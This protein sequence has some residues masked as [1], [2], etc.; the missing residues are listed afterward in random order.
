MELDAEYRPLVSVDEFLG[1]GTSPDNRA[2][3]GR[4]AA[5]IR[6]ELLER[7]RYVA[8]KRMTSTPRSAGRSIATATRCFEL[9]L[10]ARKLTEAQTG[11]GSFAL[12]VVILEHE[13]EE[14]TMGRGIL[15]WLLGVPIPVILL[16]WLF[17]GH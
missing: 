6:N 13:H 12:R 4:A 7:P 11:T 10:R 16:L 15:F 14:T 1:A 5:S 8:T 9:N 2:D 3:D 17:F